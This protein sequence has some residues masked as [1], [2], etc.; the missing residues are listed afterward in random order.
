MI[1]ALFLASLIGL[2]HIL[3]SVLPDATALP[4]S[5]FLWVDYFHAG[6]QI[7]GAFLPLDQFF[8]I[9]GLF[10]L[11]EG[12]LVSFNISTTIYRWIRG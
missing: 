1:T 2:I 3:T 7:I 8:V 12:L 6:S 9:L 5:V 11:I 4:D 10:I